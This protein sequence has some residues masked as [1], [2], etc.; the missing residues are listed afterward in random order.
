MR[1]FVLREYGTAPMV[2]EHDEPR[3]RAGLVAAPVLAAGVNPVDVAIAE[4]MLGTAEPVPR[5]LGNEAV[6]RL[7]GRVVYSQ[8]TSGSFAETTLVDPA[9]V[10]DVPDGVEPATVFL[11]GISGQ[12]AWIPLETTAGLRPG[13]TVL[14][15]GATGAAGQVATQAAKLLGA[16]RV[17]AAGRHA[18]TLDSL[19]DRGA[20]E[21]VILG[22]D[23]D[24]AALLE[25]TRGGADVVYDPLWGAPFVAAL[26]ATKPG[27]RTVTVGRSA[28]ELDAAVP[29]FAFLGKSMLTYRNGEADPQVIGHAFRRM[30]RHAAAGELAVDTTTFALEHAATAWAAQQAMPHGKIVLRMDNH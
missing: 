18:K 12:P 29:V 28:G 13:E 26:K 30:L 15:L 24:A 27:G 17:V 1:A 23:D 25:A 6:V 20:D 2:E 22:G 14:V 11:A 4:G 5:V 16:G 21:I 8:R 10:L 3:A 9:G 7:D 19:L